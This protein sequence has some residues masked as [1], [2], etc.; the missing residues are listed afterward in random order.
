MKFDPHLSSTHSVSPSVQN[1]L[2]AKG[3]YTCPV[4]RHGEIEQLA[5]MEAFACDFCRHIFEANFEQ[6]TVRVV[7]SSQ[8]MIWRWNGR[9]WRSR[10]ILDEKL[11]VFLWLISAAL[12]VLPVS[13]IG[14]SFYIFPPL[15]GN[16]LA[17]IPMAWAFFTFLSHL[18][19]VGWLLAEHYQPALYVMVKLRLSRLMNRLVAEA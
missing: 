11:T 18:M 13:M 6:Q 14:I 12:V 5:L 16:R 19:L 15:S 7:D 9:G 3:R 1:Q 2:T 17:W 4:C 10:R 8:P